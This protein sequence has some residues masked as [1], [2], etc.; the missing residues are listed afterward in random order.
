MKRTSILVL[1]LLSAIAAGSQVTGIII[2]AG[3][4]EDQATQAIGNETD[5]QKRVG[6]WQEFL[7]KYSSNPQAG[8]YGN[9]QLAQQYLDQG[10]TA[11]AREYGEKA[12]AIQPSNLDI[13]I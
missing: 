13:L 1:L 7:S 12:L 8:A 5:P 3:T 4:P 9:W 10:D 2:A 6:M 11:H